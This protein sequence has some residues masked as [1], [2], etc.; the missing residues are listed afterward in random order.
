MTRRSFG[1]VGMGIELPP[2]R[3]NDWWSPELVAQW[4]AHEANQLDRSAG[5]ET[6]SE[7]AHAILEAMGRYRGDPFRGVRE[8]RVL[9]RELPSSVMELAAA[10]DALARARVGADQIGLILT[11][12]AVPDH[13]LIPQA[14]ANHLDLGVRTD[15]MSLSMEGAQNSFH[16]QLALAGEWIAGG[17][18]DHALLI[19]SCAWTR[20]FRPDSPVSSWVGDGAT[21][22]VL[23]PVAAGRGVL[24]D[25]HETDGNFRESLGFGSPNARWYD[26]Q[27]VEAY[28]L[29][30]PTTRLVLTETVARATGVARRALTKAGLSTDDV[31]FYAAH[32][33]FGWMRE[34]TQRLVGVPNAR[35]VDTFADHASI[36][37]V[38]V[39][40]VLALAER[41][42]LLTDGDVVLT[43]GGGA[44]IT[45]ASAVMRWASRV[46]PG[47]GKSAALP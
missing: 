35:F 16:H 17:R 11:W 45:L 5:D 28:F 24:A 38:N 2:V 20:W 10:R 32:Q 37:G 41:R 34:T 15:C 8:R 21:A 22:V 42:G 18:I 36:S 19:Q 27:P 6:F 23:G 9:P 4:R 13:L 14:C 44:G 40:L 46:E 25:H 30:Q 29:D 43:M 26:G 7:G 31:T 39:P 47:L 3:T 1:I 33:A 12:S